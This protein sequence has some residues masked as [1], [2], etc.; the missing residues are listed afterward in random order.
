M[1]SNIAAPVNFCVCIS[2]FLHMSLHSEDILFTNVEDGKWEQEME[3]EQNFKIHTSYVCRTLFVKKH[4][5]YALTAS[6]PV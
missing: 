2:V 6:I 1:N 3:R 4:A 5:F